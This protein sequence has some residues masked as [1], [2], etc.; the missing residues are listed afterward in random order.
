M[1]QDGDYV[2]LYHKKSNFMIPY[3]KGNTFSCHKG[4][5][6]FEE[7]MEYGDVVQT[8]TGE[9]FA[10]LRPSLT[11][12][13]MKVARRTTIIY[14][15]EAGTI[16]LELCVESGSRVIEIGSG[17]GSLTIL[18]SRI[19]G[20]GGRV[21]SFE[22]REDHQE[23][24]KKNVAKL[25]RPERVEFFL[26]DPVEEGGFGVT[27]ADS[28]FVDVPEPWTIVPFA[29]DAIRDGGFI[30]TLSPC[31]EQVQQTVGALIVNGF[32]RIQCIENLTRNIRVERNKT[33]PYNR[34]IGHTGYLVF[35]QK[36]KEIGGAAI[37]EETGADDPLGD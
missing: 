1:L 21:Y 24:A 26:K 36:L 28:I 3:K 23:I 25:G 32:T 5:I 16:L 6:K 29:R 35:A 8:Q 12:W 7:G 4:N 2:Y 27:E 17:S 11:D 14:P 15:K 37:D 20:D 31:V 33:R 13:M 9:P 19:V 10:L 30:G 18:L 22:R 34:M